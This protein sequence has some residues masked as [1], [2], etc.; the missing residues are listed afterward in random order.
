MKKRS[1]IIGL[2]ALVVVALLVALKTGASSSVAA[3]PVRLV[4]TGP[5]GQQ[6]SGTYIADGVTNSVR[7]IAPAT[8]GLQAREV[9]YEFKREGGDG[10]FRVALYVGDLPRLSTTCGQRKGV[11]GQFRCSSDSESYWAAGF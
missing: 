6:F 5:D 3:R 7:A 10:E 2:V 8:I 4:I 9:A 11:R 1:M